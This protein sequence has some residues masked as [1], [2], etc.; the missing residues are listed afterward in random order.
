[1]PLLFVMYQ[2]IR[3][4]LTSYDISPMLTVVGHQFFN[5]DLPAVDARRARRVDPLPQHDHPVLRRPRRRPA[6]YRLHSI[7][8]LNIGLGISIIAVVSAVLQVLQSRMTLPPIDT[9][10]PDPNARIHARRCVSCR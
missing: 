4:G 5:V 10:N 8:L 3:E 2:V 9:T 1:M 7:P 6:P